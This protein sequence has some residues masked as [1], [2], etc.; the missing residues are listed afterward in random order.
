MK[1]SVF[2]LS[3]SAAALLLA[4]NFSCSKSGG[5]GGSN[6]GT[7]TGKDSVLAN[8]G[9]NIILP[10][11]TSLN[12]SVNSLDSAVVDFNAGPSGT[13]LSAVQSLFKAA[14]VNWESVSEYDGFGPA[15]T[16]QPTLANLN[17]FPTNATTIE[18][19]VSTGNNNI[20]AFANASAKGFPALD[21]LLFGTGANTLTDYTTDA[22]AA[23]R[24]AYLTAVSADIKA[25]VNTYYK[26]WSPSGGNYIATFLNGTGNSISSSL[27]LL[28]NSMDA[29]F[30]NLKNYRLGL[31]LGKQAGQ[32]LPLM[33]KE[34]EAYY[35]GISVQLALA[36]LK[37]VQNVYL[38]VGTQGAGPGLKD[39]VIAKNATY[40]GGSLNDAITSNFASA[41]S[42][43]SVIPDPLSAT[44]QSNAGPATAVY[45]TT[46]LLVV[47]LKTDMP[48]A[49]GVLITYGDND[50][51]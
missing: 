2:V 23:N 42:G 47:L 10:A 39:Y 49:L 34:V 25:E 20:N 4:V 37:A 3:G 36:Q 32:T 31:P 28:I 45:T 48:S 18:S 43:L 16:S 21:Y 40:N 35:S 7:S 14:Y 19:N 12:V 11:I 33:P 38:G 6:T 46:Q 26:G 24:K 29:D 9:N 5:S 50:G 51:D 8:L 13:K 1:R 17:L 15:T 41:V 27:G 44:I 22:L 30:E